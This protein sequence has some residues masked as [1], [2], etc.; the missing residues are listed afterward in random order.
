M[1]PTPIADF[2]DENAARGAARFHMPGHKGAGDAEKYDITEIDGAGN[3]FS[4]AGI[5]AESEHV[6]SKIFGSM[7][8]YSTE[9]S[10][11]A[12]RTM[13][14]LA[15]QGASKKVIAG[16]N[17][18]RAF[19]SAAILL[20]LDV[21]WIYPEDGESYLACRGGASRIAHAIDRSDPK[22]ACVYLTSPDY[23]GN[24]TDIKEIA[25]A[26]HER[27]VMLLVDNAH[28]AY[29]KFLEPS[30][31]PVD[32]G[33]DMCADSAHKTLH[34]LTGGAYLH[35]SKTAEEEFAAGIKETMSLFASSS[36]S[37]LI[38]RSLDLANKDP[39]LFSERLSAFVKKVE[40]IKIKLSGAGYSLIGD[41][42]LK[43][44]LRAKPYGYTG[45]GLS[46]LLFEEGVISEFHDPDFV[47]FML[48][49]DNTDSD[50]SRLEDSLLNIK[51]K[52][53]IAEQFPKY[54]VP[55]RA[56][57]PRAAY[58]AEREDVPV[59]KSIG[60]ILSSA[61]VSCPPAVPIVISGEV[62]DENGAK[63]LK[64][65]GTDTVSVVK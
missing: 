12:I 57:T 58:F 30:R 51:K 61:S 41:E 56:M 60:R 64:Y 33:A 8:Y 48:S 25:K 49:P 10:S 62:I 2:L 34:V 44:T 59:E 28:G 65:Y 29:F 11:L 43:I 26:C 27:G 17:A 53:P 13:L 38:M 22:P 63:R 9:G 42:P 32:L 18:H 47:S 54:T 36:P 15:T 20:D 7:T 4:N 23:L 1:N 24:V 6:A 19:I 52:A 5:I 31:H 37:Y 40:K 16:R 21:E 45:D 35:L 39:E 55:T 3:L 14:T 46:S 50:L